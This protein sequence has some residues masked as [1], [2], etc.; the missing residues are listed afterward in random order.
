VHF[1]SLVSFGSVGSARSFFVGAVRGFVIR[2]REQVAAVE[3]VAAAAG[4]AV[5]AAVGVVVVPR[6]PTSTSAMLATSPLSKLASA[7]SAVQTSLPFVPFVWSGEN[8][9]ERKGVGKSGK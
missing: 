2:F 3:V 6:Q 8:G 4:V 1:L 5:A 7:L 9:R